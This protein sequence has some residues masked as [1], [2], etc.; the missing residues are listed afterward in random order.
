MGFGSGKRRGAAAGGGKI[1]D[2]VEQHPRQDPSPQPAGY[3]F[4]SIAGFGAASPKEPSLPGLNLYG[5]R[6][7]SATKPGH[8][9]RGY[10]LSRTANL[11]LQLVS[12]PRIRK[13]GTFVILPNVGR[14][15]GRLY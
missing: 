5:S 2:F 11:S 12:S 13:V 6:A 9:R 4:L 3:V 8:G 10:L 7:L 15:I 14:R 1:E